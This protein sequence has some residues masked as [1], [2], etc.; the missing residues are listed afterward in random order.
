MGRIW[1]L[2]LKT[3]HTTQTY[4]H[5]SAAQV[6]AASDIDGLRAFLDDCG[7][8]NIGIIAK[9]ESVAGLQNFDEILGAV[10][11]LLFAF[12]LQLLCCSTPELTL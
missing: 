8:E 7:G 10:S 11:V 1:C 3:L 4:T 5:T 6:R 12:K 2:S 9:I